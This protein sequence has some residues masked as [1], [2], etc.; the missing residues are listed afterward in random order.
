[1]S[2][3][4]IFDPLVALPVIWTLVIIAGLLVAFALWK[5][6]RGWL[7]RGLAFV[8]FGVALANP[9]LQEENRKPLSDIV[10]LLVDESS[11]QTLSDRKAQVDAAVAKVTAEVAALP[12]TELR[13][14]RFGDGPEDAG[15]LA[16][17]AL[18]QA[19]AEEPR[20]RIAGAIL[21]TDGQVH[22]LGLAPAL[23]APLQVLLTG[24]KQDWDRHL[25]IKDAPAFAI[26]GEEFT[27][28]LR[29]EDKGAVP[30]SAEMARYST[31]ISRPVKVFWLG[32]GLMIAR[33]AGLRFT[34]F[35]A[36]L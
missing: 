11:S 8:A 22:D 3:T 31:F 26:L 32:V 29:V 33:N 23:P 19:M 20:A 13:L 9:S 25:I 24:K 21:V 15:T 16:M 35:S 27:L 5:G 28:K 34:I 18:A 10:L 1:M 6:L 17:T 12:N 14:I 4:V 30:A 2:R 36:S 7:L